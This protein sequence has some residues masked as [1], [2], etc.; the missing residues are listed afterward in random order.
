MSDV[1]WP[2]FGKSHLVEAL[3]DYQQRE[4]RYGMTSAQVRGG[5]GG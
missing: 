4:R 3:V 1:M 5:S 2:D